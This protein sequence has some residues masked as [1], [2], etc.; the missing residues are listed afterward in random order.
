[1]GRIV[2]YMHRED[3]LLLQDILN[4]VDSYSLEASSAILIFF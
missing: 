2:E 3:F 4:I 1:M